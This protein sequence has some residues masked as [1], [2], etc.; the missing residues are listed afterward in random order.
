MKSSMSST[1]DASKALDVA[2][3]LGAAIGVL[4]IWMFVAGLAALAEPTSTVTAFGPQARLLRA[5]NAAD[6][7]LVNA[8][9][10][11]MVVR[12]RTNGFVKA[13]Y[14]AGAWAVI[15]G[16]IGACGAAN[17]SA[18]TSSTSSAK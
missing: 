9:R 15:P 16:G 14:A 6:V 7:E 10:G 17:L 18:K 2:R 1:I 3:F 13:L 5:V 11:F 4:G 12:G 8:G